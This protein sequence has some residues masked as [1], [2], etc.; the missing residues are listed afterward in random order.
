MG[1]M[2]RKYN[3]LILYRVD[4]AFQLDLHLHGKNAMRNTDT[5][6]DPNRYEKNDLI[7]YTKQFPG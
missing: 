6:T 3:R 7:R 1:Y 5:N 4:K 2:S